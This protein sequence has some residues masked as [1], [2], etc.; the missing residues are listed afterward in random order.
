MPYELQGAS[1][2]ASGRLYKAC[3]GTEDI[4][5][6]VRIIATINEPAESLIEKGKLRKDHI[7]V[8]L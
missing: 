1:S 6:D 7:I 4:P 5:I 8:Y 2:S 3:R